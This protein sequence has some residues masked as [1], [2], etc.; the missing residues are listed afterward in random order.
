MFRGGEK[1]L[2]VKA[3]LPAPLMEFAVKRAEAGNR[4]ERKKSWK[5]SSIYREQTVRM[6]AKSCLVGRLRKTREGVS[7][8]DHSSLGQSVRSSKHRRKR[9]R[10]EEF[11]ALIR[12]HL[13]RYRMKSTFRLKGPG[14]T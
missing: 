9:G 1:R 8:R 4:K 5:V 13:P 3:K 12:R 2:D 6:V 14:K 7:G 11:K 10:Q